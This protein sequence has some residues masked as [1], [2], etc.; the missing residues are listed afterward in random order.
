VEPFSREARL[1]RECCVTAFAWTARDE[2]LLAGEDGTGTYWLARAGIE[3]PEQKLGRLPARV[4]SFYESPDAMQFAFAQAQDG[5]FG[6]MTFDAASGSLTDY[7]LLHGLAGLEGPQFA[8]AWSRDQ[9]FV[10]VG[11]VAAPYSL[12][13]LDTTEGVVAARHEFT[14]GYAGEL[15]WSPADNAL[16]ISTYSPDRSRHEVY[17]VDATAGETP[18]HLLGGCRLVWSPDGR[19]L[20]VK[21][22]PHTLGAEAV[23]VATGYHWRLAGLPGM[24]PVA[25]GED[26]AGALLQMRVTD[27][28]AAVLGK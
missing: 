6:L 16:A 17:V 20:A 23:N 19:F 25:W 5:E 26:E 1:V 24:T 10:A 21:A 22:E 27:R 8:I 18:R 11:P 12:Y 7:G 3:G 14:E 15:V 4:E 9:R 13:V 2:L 28:S